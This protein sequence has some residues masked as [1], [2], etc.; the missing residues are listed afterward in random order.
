M[1]L[2]SNKVVLITGAS[3]GI[4]K[5]L[6]KTLATEGAKVALVAR[7]EKQLKLASEEIEALGGNCR[8][9]QGDVTDKTRTQEIV[10]DCEKAL[11][12]IDILI[13]NA[14]VGGVS[15]AI[16]DCDVEQVWNAFEVNTRGPILYTHA[17][18]NGMVARRSGLIINMGSYASVRPLEFGPGY[19][20]S[21]AAL[22]RFSDSV[23]AAVD[24]LG[25]TVLT[26]SPG[27]VYTDMTKDFEYFKD[28]PPEAWSPIEAVCNLVSTLVKRDCSSLNGAFIHVNDDLEK[29]FENADRI[30]EQHLFSL[31]LTNFDGVVD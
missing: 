22:A 4:G 2:L 1:K 11:G 21:K 25:I 30:R 9:Y 10:T 3:R 5:A 8:F 12:P 27:L 13:N 29:L 24:T 28:L 23:A 17:V 26:I 15:G 16:W 19:A 7:D 31:R 20:A 14:G 18:L 6:A